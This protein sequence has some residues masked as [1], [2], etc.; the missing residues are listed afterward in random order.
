VIACSPPPTKAS[1]SFVPDMDMRVQNGAAALRKF[2]L[3]GFLA[4]SSVTQKSYDRWLQRKAKA[5]V[6]RD[7]KR[8][9]GTATVAEYKAAIHQAVVDSDGRDF[10][11]GE[12]L[13]WSLL[14]TWDNDEA[15]AQR[16]AY[17]KL[18]ALLPSVDHV[19]D[20]LGPADFVICSWRTNDAKNDLTL[21]ELLEL[22][23]RIL[24][25]H[26]RSAP[27]PLS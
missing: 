21:D 9:N 15:K 4:G 17:K 25:H 16:R 20:G 24:D 14:S 11:T 5:H 1:G 7:R 26:S 23:Q 12:E 2:P 22:C 18:F 13:D 8:G 6:G 27:G 19:G 10:Y 3:P